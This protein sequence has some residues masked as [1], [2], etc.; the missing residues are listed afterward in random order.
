MTLS[1][2]DWLVQF[3]WLAI[4]GCERIQRLRILQLT[5]PTAAMWRGARQTVTDCTPCAHSRLDWCK[6][7]YDVVRFVKWR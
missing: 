2:P 5:Y 6:T 4:A 7:L 3:G 1:Y